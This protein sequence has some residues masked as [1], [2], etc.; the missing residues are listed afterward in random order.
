MYVQ[1]GCH[2]QNSCHWTPLDAPLGFVVIDK[3]SGLTSHACVSRMRRVLQTK[4]VGHGGTLDPA[5]TG[6]LPIAVGQATRLLP[7]LPGE[8]T[9]RGVI[10]LGTSTNTDDLEGEVVA[11][12]AWPDLSLEEMDQALNPFRGK[13]EQCPPQVSA[14]HVN[15]ERAHARAR[16]GEV[17]DLP[18]R[19]V[20]IHSLSLQHWD[21]KEGK[22]TLEVH[23]SAGTYIRSLARD[24][25]QALGCGGCLGWLRRTQALGFV[26][27]H[28]IALPLHPNEQST[29]A[30][31]PLT[32]IPPQLALTH[33]PIRT[34]SKLERNDWSCGR[35]IPHQNGDGPTVVLSEDN[36]MLGIGIANGEDQLR[37]KVVFEARG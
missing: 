25:G 14:V 12:Q 1:A 30:M 9:Y 22:L 5:V 28:A 6:V 10:Q 4:R 21:R 8:K 11:I 15:G 13:L 29:P 36:I 20:T 34:L 3:P 31:E 37:P 32:L 26:E 19:S 23:C 7:Y 33:L 16:R 18:A 27:A 24:L 17:M 35:T 2:I